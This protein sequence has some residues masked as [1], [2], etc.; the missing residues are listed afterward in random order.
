MLKARESFCYEYP[1]QI[2][3]NCS[4]C[5]EYYAIYLVA[6]LVAAFVINHGEKYLPGEITAPIAIM[7]ENMSTLIDK[8]AIIWKCGECSIYCG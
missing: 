8:A 5:V 7:R 2:Q 6:H 3:E 4:I 1:L